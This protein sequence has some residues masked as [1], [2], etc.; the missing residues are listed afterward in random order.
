MKKNLYTLA[1]K[2]S[3]YSNF[4]KNVKPGQELTI[5][6]LTRGV[7]RNM[8]IV[9]YTGLVLFLHKNKTNSCVLFKTSAYNYNLA[10]LVRVNSI[11]LLRF[12]IHS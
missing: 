4:F 8:R 3:I 6:L 10:F 5:F 2:K 1:I 11:N 7:N 9:A 12:F